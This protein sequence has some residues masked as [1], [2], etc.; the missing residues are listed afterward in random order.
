MLCSS[1]HP[2]HWQLLFYILFVVLTVT[3]ELGM[4]R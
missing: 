1:I 3:L 4:L 2:Y